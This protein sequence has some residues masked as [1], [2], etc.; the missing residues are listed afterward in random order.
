MI[1][2][3][4]EGRSVTNTKNSEKLSKKRQEKMERMGVLEWEN[5]KEI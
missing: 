3:E 5:K 1:S 4:K 2:K